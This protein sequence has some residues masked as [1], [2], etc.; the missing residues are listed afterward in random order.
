MKAKANR[1]QMMLYD[2]IN[3]VKGWKPYPLGY[4]EDYHEPNYNASTKRV[5]EEGAT[6]V[7]HTIKTRSGSHITAQLP[8]YD[9]SGKI[10]AVIGAQKN[11]Q[12]FVNAPTRVVLL[13]TSVY[14]LSSDTLKAILVLLS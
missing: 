1:K 8:V 4:E 3:K 7:R 12:E 5:F 13:S 6:I 11:I 10:V 14:K 2:P 9:S